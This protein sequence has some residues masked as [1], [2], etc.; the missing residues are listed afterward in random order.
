[1]EYLQSGCRLKNFLS[2][3]FLVQGIDRQ[4]E[5]WPYLFPAKPNHVSERIVKAG[6]FFGEFQVAEQFG[7]H[8]VNLD[9]VYHIIMC[10]LVF[11]NIIKKC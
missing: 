11:T 8:V 10:F 7:Q 5:P 9:F 3:L 4:A 1:M 2:E 6:G